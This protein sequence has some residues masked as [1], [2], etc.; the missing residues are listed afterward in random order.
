MIRLAFVLALTAVGCSVGGSSSQASRPSEVDAAILEGRLR[1]EVRGL[2]TEVEKPTYGGATFT[3]KAT[4]VA[5]GD[6]ALSRGTYF[7]LL[8]VKR[9][10]GGDPDAPRK[11]DDFTL[12]LVQN[13]VGEMS[14]SGGYRTSSERWETEK[15]EVAPHAVIA[16]TALS[17]ALSAGK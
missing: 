1:F 7:V 13:G 10:S 4:I 15:L 16:W 6:S 12:V 11:D 14:E 9:V 8:S 5:M 17:P 3:H 2:T